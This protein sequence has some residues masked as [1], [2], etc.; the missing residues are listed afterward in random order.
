[1]FTTFERWVVLLGAVLGVLLYVARFSSQIGELRADL[2]N[3]AGAIK[4]A[5]DAAAQG[6]DRVAADQERTAAQLAE[7][8]NWHI[9]HPVI[10]AEPVAAPP[11]KGNGR[12]RV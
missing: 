4:G 9:S 2:R 11:R 5:V 8:L 3:L 1:L 10:P 6:D 7:H 12:K